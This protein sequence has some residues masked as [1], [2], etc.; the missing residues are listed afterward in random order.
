LFQVMI[1]LDLGLAKM[2][3]FNRNKMFTFI[4]ATAQI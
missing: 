3:Y 4:V 1:V 2:K